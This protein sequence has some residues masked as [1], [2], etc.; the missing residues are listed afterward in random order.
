MEKYLK[1]A[2]GLL[3]VCSFTG[4]ENS[5]G[6]DN[7][8]K[9]KNL[10]ALSKIGAGNRYKAVFDF[11]NSHD[12]KTLEAGRYEIDGDRVFLTVSFNDLRKAEDAPL[13][14]HRKYTDLQ[15]L[16]EGEE[17]FG[18]RKTSECK[19]VSAPYSDEKDIEFYA[20]SSAGAIT[21]KPG[22][23]VVF[24]PEW[25]HAPLIGS[26]KVKKCVFKIRTQ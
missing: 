9:A 7:V 18:Y 11:V 16:L 10:S 6:G 19:N 21:L 3:S 2:I 15:L 13:E 24:T 25:A 5:G 22:Q 8:P 14:S 1:S 26:G 20:D 4:C 17:S 12:L 23:F